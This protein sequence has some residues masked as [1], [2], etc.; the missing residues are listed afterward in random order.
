MTYASILRDTPD[1]VVS[2]FL[3]YGV[4]LKGDTKMLIGVN[5]KKKRIRL[6]LEDSEYQQIV[7]QAA[8]EKITVDYMVRLVLKSGFDICVFKKKT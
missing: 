2:R 8:K 7:E 6:V 3:L 1:I 5:H 4:L